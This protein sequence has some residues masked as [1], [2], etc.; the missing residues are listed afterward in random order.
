MV[1][2]MLIILLKKVGNT[3]YFLSISPYEF[4]QGVN[5]LIAFEGNH[6]LVHSLRDHSTFETTRCRSRLRSRLSSRED[7]PPVPDDPHFFTRVCS[8][9]VHEKE[10]ETGCL[11]PLTSSTI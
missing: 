1:T 4:E 8:R 7:G 9:Y 2:D 3:L 11:E 10:V 6:L 5:H